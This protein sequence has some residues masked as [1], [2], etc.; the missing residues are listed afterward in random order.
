MHSIYYYP[1]TTINSFDLYD[2]CGFIEQESPFD[3]SSLINSPLSLDSESGNMTS[4]SVET[5][6]VLNQDPSPMVLIKPPFPPTI[7]IDDLVTSKPNGDKPSKSS[8]AFI[9]YR[10]A[11]VKELHSRGINLQMTQIS[12]MVSESWKQEPDSVK[13]EYKRLA[14]AAKKRYKEMWPSKQRRRQ[15]RKHQQQ[16][17]PL[18]QSLFID[19]SKP[20]NELGLSNL[21]QTPPQTA[22]DINQ[23]DFSQSSLW[24]HQAISPLQNLTL[25][26]ML[27]NSTEGLYNNNNTPNATPLLKNEIVNS[28]STV[29]SPLLNFLINNNERGINRNIS[30]QNNSNHN[31]KGTLL[32]YHQL[33]TN[34]HKDLKRQNPHPYKTFAD[35]ASVT[36][37]ALHLV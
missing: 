32:E 31:H 30:V 37:F 4:S 18:P 13:A 36:F 7:N 8:N 17:Q 5:S 10:K 27:L 14:E 16:Q 24:S 26:P 12:P 21:T 15:H 33:M 34:W 6:P 2:E 1:T 11:Y 23:W 25:D 19:N 9:I 35:A 3:V 20:T 22:I 28:S 29:N